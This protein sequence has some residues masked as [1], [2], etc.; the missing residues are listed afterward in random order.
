MKILNYNNDSDMS[1]T[2]EEDYD[3]RAILTVEKEGEKF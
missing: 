1:E 2:R 3:K